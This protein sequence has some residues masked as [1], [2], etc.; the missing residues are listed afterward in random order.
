MSQEN[1]LE[2]LERKKGIWFTPSEIAKEIDINHVSVSN[3]LNSMLKSRQDSIKIVTKEIIYKV[4]WNK[5]F[6]KI[7]KDDINKKEDER[8]SDFI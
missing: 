3:A 8:Y 7:R 4:S 1:I 5:R 2:F 6:E